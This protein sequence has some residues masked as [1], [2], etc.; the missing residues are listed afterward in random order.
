M[1]LTSKNVTLKGPTILLMNYFSVTNANTV[2]L[3]LS[4]VC[5][6]TQKEVIEQSF[7]N[8]T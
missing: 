7:K 4:P 6:V 2:K 8:Y 1:Q 5:L 3:T